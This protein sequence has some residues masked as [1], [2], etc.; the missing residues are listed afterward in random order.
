[1]R[2]DILDFSFNNIDNKLLKG[3]SFL[4]EES[5]NKLIK[6]VCNGIPYLYEKL[7]GGFCNFWMYASLKDISYEQ[8]LLSYELQQSIN[9]SYFYKDYTFICDEKEFKKIKKQSEVPIS[10]IFGNFYDYDQ[11][12]VYYNIIKKNMP[13]V[14]FEY[15]LS[16]P[17]YKKYT[18][19]KIEK[20]S[21]AD[22][23][24]S[25][26]TYYEENN[27]YKVTF[28]H[29]DDIGID[30]TYFNQKTYNNSL[31]QFKKFKNLDKIFIS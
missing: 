7:G 29:E 16:E 14:K 28:I 19:Y 17:V 1:M 10:L 21:F 30:K 15:I 3:I 5:S 18:I 4:E 6:K 25:F 9:K 31:K 24:Y 13:T 2:T 20:P 12:M 8:Y 23:K 26:I 11:L 22:N 27:E